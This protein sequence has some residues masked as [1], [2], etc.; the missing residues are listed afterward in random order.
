LDWL[1][2]GSGKVMTDGGGRGAS[3][4]LGVVILFRSAKAYDALDDVD[5]RD[6]FKTSVARTWPNGE[7]ARYGE[8]RRGLGS[9]YRGEDS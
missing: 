8:V 3:P 2:R 5:E 4:R 1:D 7:S 6:G 9:E